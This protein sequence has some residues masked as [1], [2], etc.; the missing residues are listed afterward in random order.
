MQGS[1][2]FYSLQGWSEPY[3]AN[4]G[5]KAAPYDLGWMYSDELAASTIA[6]DLRRADPATYDAGEGP[7]A[8]SVSQA[9]TRSGLYVAERLPLFAA[10]IATRALKAAASIPGMYRL[11]TPGQTPSLLAIRY[12]SA[13]RIAGLTARAAAVLQTRWLPVLGGLGILALLLRAFVRARGGNVRFWQVL[14]SCCSDIRRSS[15]P[16]VTSSIS[17]YSSGSA[18]HR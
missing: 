17:R 9:F 6:A 16:C 7:R 11:L 5:L 3:R 13:S 10:D 8:L 4:L 18:W 14:S 2:G 15:S 12:P 1:V